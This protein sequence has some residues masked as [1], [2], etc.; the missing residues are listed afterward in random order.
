MT[1]SEYFE[2]YHLILKTISN[3]S[4]ISM[5][6]LINEIGNKE[7]LGIKLAQEDS[8]RFV[9][10]LVEIMENLIDDDLVKGNCRDVKFS[11]PLIDINHLTTSGYS[12]LSCLEKPDFKTKA[13]N[14]LKE[15]G[16]P[17]TPTSIGKV[18]ARLSFD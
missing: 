10:V 18:I 2:M 16:I 1:A 3:N 9:D 15:E 8:K 11:H 17:M 13:K 5:Q 14:I 4:N 6:G 7:E 12:Y